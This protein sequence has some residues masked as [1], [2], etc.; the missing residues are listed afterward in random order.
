MMLVNYYDDNRR[1]DN[2]EFNYD[3]SCD[4]DDNDDFL[5]DIKL[6]LH[7][8]VFNFNLPICSWNSFYPSLFL[9]IFI[10]SHPSHC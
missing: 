4:D 3:V 10:S 2:R 1:I 6:A 7:I 5:N 9:P 8:N